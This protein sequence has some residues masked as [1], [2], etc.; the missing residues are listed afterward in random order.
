MGENAHPVG[1]LF[2]CMGNICRSPTAEG[3]FRK[4]VTDAG[5]DAHFHI[6]SA[7]TLDYHAG[8]APDLRAQETGRRRGIDLSRQRARQVRLEDY[9]RFHYVVAMDRQNARYLEKQCPKRHRHR[10]HLMM[11]F[12]ASRS[13]REV[14]DPYYGGDDGFDRVFDLVTEA[15][16]GLLDTIRSE[17]LAGRG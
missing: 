10:L 7:G 5:L 8:E 11:D 3:I 13:E 6:D 4:L 15:A 17:H 14:P 1:V 9:E 12:A 16:Q 2:V